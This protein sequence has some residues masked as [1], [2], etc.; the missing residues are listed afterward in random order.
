MTDIPTAESV[1]GRY[2]RPPALWLW[3]ALLLVPLLVAVL[4]WFFV[5]NT[6]AGDDRGGAPV[7]VAT[8]RQSVTVTATVPDEKTH[9]SLLD[10]LQPIAGDHEV[11]DRITVTPGQP[12]TDFDGLSEVL[13]TA[14]AHFEEFGVRVEDNQVL[15]SGASPSGDGAF[16]LTDAATQQFGGREIKSDFRDTA[17]TL[18][19]EDLEAQIEEQLQANPVNF[20]RGSPSIDQASRD[21]LVEIGRTLARC[22]S[23]GITVRG[24]TD[25]I[26]SEEVNQP[27]AQARA[28]AAAAILVEAGVDQAQVKAEGRTAGLGDVLS[29][30]ELAPA[31]RRVEILIER[32]KP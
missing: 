18:T 1:T 4:S 14:D 19:C 9:R 21:R 30:G 15:L 6:G 10:A 8:S 12:V 28:D 22:G 3:I 23:T 5:D 16:D 2:R 13:R 17:D 26:G 32:E 29:D 25:A 24:H 11:I 31:E 20:E 27:L 7:E